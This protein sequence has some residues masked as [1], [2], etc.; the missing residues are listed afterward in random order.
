[1]PLSDTPVIETVTL[2]LSVPAIAPVENSSTPE[3][4]DA[5]TAPPAI[6]TMP[7][8]IPTITAVFMLASVVSS[9]KML[10]L[11]D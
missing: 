9:K 11:S 8:L 5:V 6:V 2:A 7:L 3:I 1:M 4:C 10:P